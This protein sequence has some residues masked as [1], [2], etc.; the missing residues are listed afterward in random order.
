MSTL[1][2]TQTGTLD[3]VAE[4]FLL[5]FLKNESFYDL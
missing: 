1:F 4:N 3:L 5:A 2:L